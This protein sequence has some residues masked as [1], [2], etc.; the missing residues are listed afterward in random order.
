MTG[1]APSPQLALYKKFTDACAAA[2]VQTMRECVDPDAFFAVTPGQ[3]RMTFQ[4]FAQ[5]Q[6]QLCGITVPGS[7]RSVP[8]KIVEQGS[9]IA[10]QYYM[11]FTLVVDTR[12][13]EVTAVDMVTFR[14]GKIVE[15][16]VAFDRASTREQVFSDIDFR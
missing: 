9:T 5:L 3:G 10:V 6:R 12:H 4:Q 7:H 2:D 11:T 16:F 1:A 13:V 8:Q 15:L 14:E